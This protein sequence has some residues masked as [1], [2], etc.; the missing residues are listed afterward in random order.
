[1]ISTI[2]RIVNV[3]EERKMSQLRW[4][5]LHRGVFCHIVH[6]HPSGLTWSRIPARTSSACGFQTG[7]YNADCHTCF[8]DVDRDF[9]RVANE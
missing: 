3:N 7:K 2:I 5:T 6:E 1:M 4:N 8:W 9:R